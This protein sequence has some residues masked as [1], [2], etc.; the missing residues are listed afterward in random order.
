MADTNTIAE[1]G[2]G[3]VAKYELTAETSG[4]NLSTAVS[5]TFSIQ[6]SDPSKTIIITSDDE[7]NVI[8]KGNGYIVF[9]D[10]AVTGTG[11]LKGRVTMI[12][13]DTD[14]TKPGV[15]ANADDIHYRP[16]VSLS[17][18]VLKVS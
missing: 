12:V 8:P 3:T 18:D 14:Y 10:T 5:W 17:F 6:G 7:E 13:S 1:V 4:I 11:T 16:E 9:I 2:V 15:E